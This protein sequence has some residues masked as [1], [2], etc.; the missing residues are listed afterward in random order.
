MSRHLNVLPLALCLLFPVPQEDTT[1][2]L[3]DTALI[4]QPGNRAKAK[5]AAAK[6]RYRIATPAVPTT[7]IA[8]DTVV[9][10]TLWR[11]RPS[12]STDAGERLLVRGGSGG[13]QLDT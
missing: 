2:K 9:G 13:G 7:Q 1:R 12:R 4:N 3:W 6:R 5:A 8:G 10:V 11:L